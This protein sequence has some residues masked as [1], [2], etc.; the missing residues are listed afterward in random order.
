MMPDRI[1]KQ[2]LLR[3][4]LQRVWEAISDAKQFGYWFGVDFDGPFVAGGRLTGRIAPTRVDAE[5]GNLQV[6]HAGKPFH[7]LIER[8]EPQQ[9][10]SFH[11]HPV[12][13]EPGSDYSSEPTTLVEFRLQATTEG[14]LLTISESGFS[15]IPLARR[16]QA[17]TANDHGWTLQAG[18]I[19]KYLELDP[20]PEIGP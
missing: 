11:W 17:F 14:T 12:A 15:Q 8:I 10:Y 18:L 7:I 9:L 20:P 6:P 1:E 16:A 5:V 13:V 4:P 2:V 19:R 3:A